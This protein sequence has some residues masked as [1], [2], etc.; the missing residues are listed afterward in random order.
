MQE[1]T[2]IVNAIRSFKINRVLKRINLRLFD[3]I[4]RKQTRTTNLLQLI[5]LLKSRWNN[6]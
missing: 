1:I 2:F 6:N 4:T 5:R 3:N